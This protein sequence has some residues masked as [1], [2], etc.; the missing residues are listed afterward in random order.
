LTAACPD[1]AGS[2]HYEQWVAGKRS[3]EEVI[4]TYRAEGFRIGP[5]K[6]YQLARDTEHARLIVCS[7][8]PNDLAHRLLLDPAVDFQEALDR[9]LEDIGPQERIAVLPHAATTIPYVDVPV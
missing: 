5:H 2:D 8:M 4:R 6:A 7:D 9:A 1:G 3:P